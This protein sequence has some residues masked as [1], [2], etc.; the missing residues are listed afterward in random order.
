MYKNSQFTCNLKK[1]F[2][3]IQDIKLWCLNAH[4][5]MTCNDYTHGSLHVIVLCKLSVWLRQI[6][7]VKLITCDTFLFEI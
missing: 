7:M 5:L 4:N 6:D 2:V 3:N 1:L